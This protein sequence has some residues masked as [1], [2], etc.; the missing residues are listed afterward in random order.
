VSSQFFTCIRV[1]LGLSCPLP[2]LNMCELG[3]AACMA[4]RVSNE[5]GAPPRNEEDGSRQCEAEYSDPLS[6]QTLANTKC[7]GEDRL[8]IHPRVLRMEETP[9][10][11][12]TVDRT[13]Y[14]AATEANDNDNNSSRG[15]YVLN[16]FDAAR[17]VGR[18]WSHL[19]K[20]LKSG[21]LFCVRRS[22][23]IIVAAGHVSVHLCSPLNF[24]SI[25]NSKLLLF[26]SV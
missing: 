1:V 13:Q 22:K 14:S 6:V 24:N 15:T 2:S 9:R 26:I 20:V 8:E 16:E 12:L 25:F 10:A 3:E 21:P 5:R 11:P 17:S 18:D 19:L 4:D 23:Y 7:C